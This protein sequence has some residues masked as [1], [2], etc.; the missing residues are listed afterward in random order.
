MSSFSWSAS[1]LRLPTPKVIDADNCVKAP[2]KWINSRYT[3]SGNSCSQASGASSGSKPYY[4]GQ[5]YLYRGT[6]PVELATA[7]ASFSIVTKELPLHW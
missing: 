7:H 2:D 6:M 4:P 1:L 5:E 3:M